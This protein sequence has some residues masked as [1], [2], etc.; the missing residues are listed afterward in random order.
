MVPLLIQ[1]IFSCFVRNCTRILS[2]MQN[3]KKDRTDEMAKICR[4]A[5]VLYEVLQAVV[6]PGKIDAETERYAKDVEMKR[7]Q[8]EPYNIL[9]LYTLG[10]KPRIMEFPEIKA[11]AH[12]LRN[13]SNL[14][15]PRMQSTPGV[16][17]VK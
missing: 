9:P 2:E 1:E 5:T 10:V 17:R 7:K 8:C 3:I 14:P 12:A 6:S 11:A 16:P 4:T 13:V 15:M